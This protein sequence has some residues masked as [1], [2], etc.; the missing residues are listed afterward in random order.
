M[1]FQ[2]FDFWVVADHDVGV[3]GIVEGVVLVVGLGVVEAFEGGELGDDGLGEGVGDFELGDV[4]GA[5]L[6]LLVGGVEDGGAVG[7]AD[8]VA[9]AIE[10]GGVVDDGE[11]DLE[12]FAV[13]DPGGVVDDF[14]GFGVAGGFGGDL[15]VGG[16]V[17]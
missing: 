3:A 12:E 11:E 9:L 8:I 15:V 5:D 7:G 1:F 6:S 14:Y 2:G 16:G 4:G 17:G 10:L 13:G